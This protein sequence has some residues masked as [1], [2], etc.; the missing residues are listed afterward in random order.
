MPP[1][2]R[3]LN[4]SNAI[5]LLRLASAPF[6]CRAIAVG[7]WRLAAALFWLAVV[8]DWTD[9][10]LA[11]AR[12]EASRLGGLLDHASDA[13]LVSAGLA[14]LAFD[15]RIT[16]WLPALVVVAFVQ[17]VLDSRWLAGRALRASAL[18]RWNGILYFVPLGTVVTREAIGLAWPDD[19]VVA[20]LAW[21]LV[22]STA[23]SMLDRA[24]ALV[25]RAP[26][27]EEGGARAADAESG[28][29]GG[30]EKV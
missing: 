15:G 16:R 9:G 1:V 2:G 3:R 11:R 27:P 24:L 26:S 17:Y 21:A 23:M 19:R 30:A 4:L 5:T 10:R 25:R 18:G 20:L 6:L 7:Q 29:T 22:G 8:T 14:V 28:E 12:G 13:C